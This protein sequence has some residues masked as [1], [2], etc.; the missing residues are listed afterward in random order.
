M[1]VT[2]FITKFQFEEVFTL[3]KMYPTS[4]EIELCFKRYDRDGDGKWSFREFA[5]AILPR[6]ESYKDLCIKRRPFNCNMDYARAECF[7]PDTQHE[8]GRLLLLMLNTEV[9]CERM[10]QHLD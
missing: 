8:F 7:L 3:L 1:S 6:N 10:R 2:G 9:R 5:D 4:V